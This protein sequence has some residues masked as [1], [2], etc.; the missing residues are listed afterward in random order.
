MLQD[1]ADVDDDDFEIDPDDIDE[2]LDEQAHELEEHRSAFEPHLSK[3]IVVIMHGGPP[4]GGPP[5]PMRMMMGRGMGGMSMPMRMGYRRYRHSLMR[6]L[7]AL[8]AGA[9][10]KFSSPM[11]DIMT[12]LSYTY[13]TSAF[14]R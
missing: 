7:P 4:M 14:V 3:R 10:E 9:G 1:R 12:P 6:M 8:L 5:M 2:H 11:R 13:F